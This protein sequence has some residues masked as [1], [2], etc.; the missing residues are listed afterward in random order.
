MRS[1]VNVKEAAVA[2]FHLKGSSW[3]YEKVRNGGDW[4]YKKHGSRYQSFGNFNYGASG[5]AF[6]F[7][8]DTLLR[9]AGWAQ[10]KAGTSRSDWGEAPS[11][12]E[13]YFGVGGRAPFGDDP[14]D[15]K[16]IL[17]GIEYYRNQGSARK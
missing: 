3:F 4:D 15:R 10:V 2:R 8:E 7:S 16:W 1:D 13:A 6:G 5:A 9:M 12:W 11:K 17:H 14:I